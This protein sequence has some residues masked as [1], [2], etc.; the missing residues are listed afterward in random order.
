[1]VPSLDQ[2]IDHVVVLKPMKL[3]NE[4]VGCLAQC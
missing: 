2:I 3:Q 4:K 1:M